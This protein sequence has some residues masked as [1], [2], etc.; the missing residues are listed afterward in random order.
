VDEVVTDVDVD[1]LPAGG[2]G[3]VA[4]KGA[5]LRLSRP[6]EFSTVTPPKLAQ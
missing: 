4:G 1:V 3:H 5:V 6:G 2:V